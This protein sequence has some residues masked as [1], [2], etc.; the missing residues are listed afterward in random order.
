MYFLQH[1]IFVFLYVYIYLPHIYIYILFHNMLIRKQCWNCKAIV[2]VGGTGFSWLWKN[3]IF[4]K[5]E[6]HKIKVSPSC[7]CCGI[8]EH[9]T[10]ISF[11]WLKN[12]LKREQLIP[13]GDLFPFIFSFQ[14]TT[15]MFIA[16]S[17]FLLE[18]ACVV[19]P[20]ANVHY[21]RL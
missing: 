13:L 12:A 5:P 20:F 4:S 14:C 18:I 15:I 2:I 11:P 9:S 21:F 17:V 10:S 6:V 1:F 7:S 3:N 8:K 19:Y 16:N